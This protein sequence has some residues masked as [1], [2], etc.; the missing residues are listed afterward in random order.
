MMTSLAHI[1]ANANIQRLSL[2]GL[3]K[4]VGK[5][6]TTNYLLKMLLSEQ[7]Y[8]AEDLALTS[9]GLDGEASDALTG[10]P[11][12]RYV[13]AEGLLIATTTDLLRQAEHDG[14]QIEHLVQL[15][16]RTALGPVVLARVLQPGRIMLAGPTLLRD[17]RYTLAQFQNYGARLS[18]I[19]GAINRLGAATP[20]VTDACIICTGASVGATPE[21]V[22]RR[23]ADV[24]AR[25]TTP[26]TPLADVYRKFHPE[27]RLLTFV[28]DGSDQVNEQ[29]V[30]MY[31]GSME[32]AVEAC[33][34]VDSMQ[35]KQTM[36]HSVYF[37]RGA[38]TEELAR[39]LLAQLPLSQ[40]GKAAEVIVNDGT[41]IFCHSVVLQRLAARGLQ[42]SVADPIRILA[43]TINPYAPEYVCS[44][45]RLL[46]AL[47]KDLTGP[48]LPIFDV[49]SGLCFP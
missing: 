22:A 29:S 44:P 47:V 8:H 6:T 46:D 27:A 31:A 12:P 1:I 2:I 24:F 15:P 10:L 25:L 20:A 45:Q 16:G 36:Q 35:G 43:M 5:T 26:Q 14:A 13:P 19:D 38:F 11:K 4:N 17:L 18:I 28:A 32:P 33:W 42:V 9:L 37:L 23:T 21:L 7:L 34:I 49:V 40:A 41:K 48:Q 39:A 3:A 30:E